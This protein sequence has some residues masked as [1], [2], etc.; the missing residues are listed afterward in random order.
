MQLF[1]FFVV[2][3]LHLNSVTLSIPY[4]LCDIEPQPHNTMYQCGVQN[5]FKKCFCI[6]Q[7][8]SV[9]FFFLISGFLVIFIFDFFFFICLKWFSLNYLQRTCFKDYKLSR[10]IKSN[11]YFYMYKMKI[12][13]KILCYFYILSFIFVTF[14]YGLE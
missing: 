12:I 9:F 4:T 7:K 14:S 1:T 10:I 3:L 8:I 11:K 2:L 6:F 13:L 5:H